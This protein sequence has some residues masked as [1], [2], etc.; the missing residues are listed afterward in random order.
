MALDTSVR[1]TSTVPAV[2]WW[3]SMVTVLQRELRQ[4]TRD[5]IALSLSLLA[6]VAAAIIASIA[7]GAPQ[8]VDA[9]L[10]V[11]T[12]DDTRALVE[13]AVAAN[14]GPDLDAIVVSDP[15]EARELIRQGKV[16][17]AIVLDLV[18]RRTSV[19]SN[20]IEPIPE[21]LAVDLAHL[22]DLPASLTVLSSDQQ[23]FD[24]QVATEPEGHVLNG[25]ELYGPAVA[26]FFLFLTTGIVARSLH[27]EKSAGTLIRMRV[28][29][30]RRDV[31]LASKGI[32]MLLL[33]AAEVGAVLI[34]MQIFMNADFGSVV[35]SASVATA[36]TI[37]IGAIALLIATFA[38]SLEQA[39][40]L[41]IVI[42]LVFAALGGNLLPLSNLP[43]G[44]RTIANITPNG[45]A[46]RA[47][48]EV[49]AGAGLEDVTG[50]ILYL[51]AFALVVG[52]IAF[53]RARK[54]VA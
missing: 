16:N 2:T 21:A 36:I 41:E 53:A 25:G 51:L 13:N 17:A 26:I 32:G 46:I 23:A 11:V 44:A 54:I 37:A 28:F 42:A 5:R 20:Q 10:A 4:M 29:A 24:P 48:R 19:I 33:G 50:P 8:Q 45:I 43:D 35:A 40:G 47:F 27:V 7:L 12:S 9:T 52:A 31:I 49:S 6:P 39:Q 22:V 1:R 14:G 34:T 30:V 38:R 3:S 15:H 18:N